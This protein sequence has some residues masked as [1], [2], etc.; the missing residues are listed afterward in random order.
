MSFWWDVGSSGHDGGDG[1]GVGS[2]LP[3]KILFIY[4]GRKI[5][6][7]FLLCRHLSGLHVELGESRILLSIPTTGGDEPGVTVVPGTCPG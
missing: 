6:G 5:L 1:A 2:F 7:G 3:S 4:R